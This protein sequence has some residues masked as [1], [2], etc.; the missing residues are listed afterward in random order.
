MSKSTLAVLCVSILFSLRAP[1]A[2]A[3][4]V[5]VAEV[6]GTVTDPTGAAIGGAIVSM[7]ETD[8]QIV[9]STVTDS[10]GNYTLLELPVGPYRLDVRANGFRNHVESGLVLEVGN[11]IRVN[12]T[13]EVGSVSETVEVKANASLVE[14]KENSVSSVVDQQRITELPL[15]GGRRPS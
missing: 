7:T 10:L 4:T 13:M 3:Q 1:N 11:N 15:D 8:K 2:C 14:T 5:A 12:V 9:R 6:S